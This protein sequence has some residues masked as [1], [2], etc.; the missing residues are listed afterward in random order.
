VAKVQ[1]EGIQGLLRELQHLGERA[2]RIENQALREGAEPV[3]QA[4]RQKVRVS[5]KNQP[6][7]RYN[8]EISRVKQEDNI[9]YVE[10]GPNKQTNWRARFLEF[11]TSKMRP[12]PFMGPAAAESR[13]K[14][15][16]RIERALRRGLGLR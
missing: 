13:G 3:A 5:N 2:N 7:I 14:V 12:R 6:H 9:K 16:A 4:M 10:V 11:G 1:M 15:L 8:I